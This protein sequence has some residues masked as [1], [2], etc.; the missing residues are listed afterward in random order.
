MMECLVL[1]LGMF[2]GIPVGSCF[3]PESFVRSSSI[4]KQKKKEVS[5]KVVTCSCND[6][7]VQ[8]II[9]QESIDAT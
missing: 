4:V 1:F 6:M 7:R 3:F 9:S 2:H 8:V 5:E